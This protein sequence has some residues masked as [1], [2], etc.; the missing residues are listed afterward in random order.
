MRSS[1]PLLAGVFPVLATP[2]HADGSPDEAG[3]RRDRALRDRR[4]R[5]RRRLPGVASEY[6]TLTP[7][8]RA[9]LSDI[10]AVE[11]QGRAAFVVGGSA[12]DMADDRSGCAGSARRRTRRR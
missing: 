1:A 11:A 8:E 6:E 10:V 4:G 3:L 12:P 7:E 2:F 9:R 5:R